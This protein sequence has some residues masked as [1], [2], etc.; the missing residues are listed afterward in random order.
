[1][2]TPSCSRCNPGVYTVNVRVP[3]QG[4]N[5]LP[6]P[7]D[8][9][10]TLTHN[11]GFL[12][13]WRYPY[14]TVHSTH[15]VD[16]RLRTTDNNI[17]QANT[18]LCNWRIVFLQVSYRSTHRHISYSFNSRTWHNAKML[19]T[20]TMKVNKFMVQTM[21]QILWPTDSKERLGLCTSVQSSLHVVRRI[22]TYICI[23]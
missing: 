2:P 18:Y 11:L 10:Q 17:I 22:N 23:A 7:L 15:T 12:V 9:I 16:G 21:K 1:M 4:I 20:Q 8:A 3:V 19:T 13:F 6:L 14:F 5:G